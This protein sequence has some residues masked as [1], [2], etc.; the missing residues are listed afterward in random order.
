MKFNKGKCEVL[1]LGRSIPIYQHQ[2][3]SSFAGKRHILVDT[4]LT[5]SKQLWERRPAASWAALGRALRAHQG[6]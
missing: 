3:E 2:V 6:R 5:V 1:H 4:K